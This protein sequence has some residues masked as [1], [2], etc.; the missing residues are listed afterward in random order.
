MDPETSCSNFKTMKQRCP[1]HLF[2]RT[3]TVTASIVFSGRKSAPPLWTPPP[4]GGQTGTSCCQ[5][6]WLC[7]C[8]RCL[9]PHHV[10]TLIHHL[11]LGTDSL[12]LMRQTLWRTGERRDVD[13]PREPCVL[14]FGERMFH[15]RLQLCQ[16]SR[17]W[18]S[19]SS[20]H[21]SPYGRQGFQHRL[22]RKH[23]N[24]RH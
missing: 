5:V 8:C 7:W 6:L 19:S 20:S 12:S 21:R 1:P 10:T 3:I 4:S 14:M 13:S 24:V 15:M 23:H 16:A 2:H 18:L 9:L 22:E 17:A 11:Q